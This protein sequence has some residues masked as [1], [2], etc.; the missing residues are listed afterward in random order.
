VTDSSG[1]AKHPV[2]AVTVGAAATALSL[3]AETY[4]ACERLPI[5]GTRL[6]DARSSL[7]LRGEEILSSGL[8]PV[9]ATIT[10]VAVELVDRVL[11][12]LDL[13][14]LVRERI[15][16]VALANE[17]IAGVDLPG[18]IRESTGT[19]TAEVMSDVR[20]QGERADD[21]VSGLVDRIL[22]RDKDS[23]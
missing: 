16:L 12:E 14:E 7:E 10:A 20:S 18:I 4:R 3:V 5:V 17:I 9:M 6:R 11:D 22:G 19:V 15:D 23:R 1:L 8:E 13:N 2:T 21:A